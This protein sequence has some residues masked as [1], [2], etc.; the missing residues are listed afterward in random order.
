MLILCRVQGF[1]I[2]SKNLQPDTRRSKE[3]DKEKI[4]EYA[5]YI[6]YGYIGAILGASIFSIETWYWEIKLYGWSG[7]LIQPAFI[8]VL[9]ILISSIFLGIPGGFAAGIITQKWWGAMIGG[10]I[11]N[12]IIVKIIVEN[13]YRL[14]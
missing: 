5:W 14:R 8:Y 6:A 3:M 11:P 2:F 9:I 13:W 1:R 10:F 4:K 7:H 12:F